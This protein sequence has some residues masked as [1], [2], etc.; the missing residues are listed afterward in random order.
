MSKKPLDSQQ[1]ASELS[2][3]RLFSRPQ[4]SE[5][6]PQ[7]EPDLVLPTP[8]VTD[9]TPDST[10]V[11]DLPR[12]TSRE[13]RRRKP[14]GLLLGYPTRDEIQELSFKLRDTL[15]VKVQAEVPKEWQD[16]LEELAH[17]LDVKKLELYRFI[18]AEFLGKVKRKSTT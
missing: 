11:R 4:A 17:Q 14:G 18:L 6:Q 3:S 9:I 10:Y 15:K 13:L 2:A 16:D 7:P 5:V 12:E 1:I 8:P